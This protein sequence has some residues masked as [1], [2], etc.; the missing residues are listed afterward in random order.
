MALQLPDDFKE[1]L[2]LLNAN[3]VRYLVVGGY[4]VGLHGYPRAT[5]DLDIWIEVSTENAVGLTQAVREFGFD[6]P[7]VSRSL[8]LEKDKIIRMGTAPLMIE[9]M[10]DI[11]GVAFEECYKRRDIIQINNIP[12]PVISRPDLIANKLATGRF[13]DKDDLEYFEK[14]PSTKGK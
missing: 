14:N 8:F 7:E 4:A 1:F 2:K 6:L 11:S 13:K 3:G 12:I 9:L 5:G 10:T